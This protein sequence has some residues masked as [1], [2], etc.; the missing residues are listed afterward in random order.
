MQMQIK[1]TGEIVEIIPAR[2]GNKFCFACAAT[3]KKYQW[4]ELEP[5]RAR[6]STFEQRVQAIPVSVRIGVAGRV[7]STKK[8]SA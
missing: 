2:D 5:V 1:A 4:E 3:G 8:P 6:T 7:T